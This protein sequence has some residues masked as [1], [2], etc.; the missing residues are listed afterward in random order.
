MAPMLNS[1]PIIFIVRWITH[2]LHFH[3]KYHISYY[4][5]QYYNFCCGSGATLQRCFSSIEQQ[6]QKSDFHNIIFPKKS[7]FCF[8]SKWCEL[9]W[10]IEI[11]AAINHSGASSVLSTHWARCNGYIVRS[12]NTWLLLITIMI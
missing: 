4:L 12:G 11:N 5:L 3:V 7:I 8:Y 2:L 6:E 9:P 10:V 1:H